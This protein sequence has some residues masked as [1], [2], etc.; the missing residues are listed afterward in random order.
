MNAQKMLQLARE[1]KSLDDQIE[2]PQA[3]RTT[4]QH[5]ALLEQVRG[6]AVALAAIV[7]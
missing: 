3:P 4:K 5:M 2:C 1:I 7:A 6:R